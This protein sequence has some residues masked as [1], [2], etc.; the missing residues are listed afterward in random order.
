[1]VEKPKLRPLDIQPVHYQ[2]Q[3]MFYLR[4]PLGLSD[5][6]IILPPGLLQ[7]LIFF[8]GERTID[9]IYAAFANFVDLPIDI[10][11]IQN[12]IDQ[13]DAA[14]LLDNDHSRRMKDDHLHEYHSQS[15]RP[16]ALAGLSYAADPAELRG[17]LLDYGKGDN[18]NG[19]EP[20][21]GRG[22]ISP[23]IDYQRGG[24]VYAQVWKRAA[25][26]V[27][28]ADLVLVFGTDHNGSFGKVTLTEKPYATPFGVI[29]TEPEL[30]QRLAAAV[31]PTA[32]EEELHHRREHS[33]E[34]SAVWYHY[35]HG[36]NPPPMI[37]ILCGSFH[38]FVINGGH[39]AEDAVL[40]RFIRELKAA[41]NGR[42]VL[43]VASVDLAHVGPNFGDDYVMDGDRRAE[44]AD[45]DRSLM[46]A[47]RQ[48]DAARFYREIATVEDRNR[49]CGFS[50]IYLMLRYLGET[51]GV[52][53]AYEHCGADTADESLVSICSMLLN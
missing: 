21:Q 12:M 7:M 17:E 45:S 3:E 33:I 18:L 30:V 49:I 13:L 34:L 51:E 8:D 23:H 5:Y 1:V 16:A 31:G 50:S 24:P 40:N 32:Y 53:V 28:E 47:I 46:D 27:Q 2:G 52:K 9:Q 35:T 38:H 19:W 10:S 41:T 37:P 14:C 42:R 25:A 48:G 26:A 36:D 39:P 22:I 6:Q 11:L 44:L 15:F 43:A 29:P 20:W 4:D